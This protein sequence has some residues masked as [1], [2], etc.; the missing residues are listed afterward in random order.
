VNKNLKIKCIIFDITVLTGEEIDINDRKKKEIEDKYAKTPVASPSYDQTK[1]IK[2]VSTIQTKYM[3]KIRQR[4][5]D[6]SIVDA[7]SPLKDTDAKLLNIAK[8]IPMPNENKNPS[9]WLLQ[10][11]MGD[12]LDNCAFRS[13][14]IAV[15]GK[16]TSD[17]NII[18]QLAGQIP[19]MNFYKIHNHK[20][21]KE[22]VIDKFRT[23]EKQMDILPKEYLLFTSDEEIIEA[24]KERGYFTCRYRP[25]NGLYGRNSTDFVATNA[26]QCQDAIEELNGIAFNTSAY[27]SRAMN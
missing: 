5:G 19:N 18:D 3:N 6:K 20:D 15:I 21:D 22:R 26:I 11:G 1:E 16:N 10:T 27:N 17:P 12:L 8:A 24:G 7:T 2:N 4:I 23:M 25:Q 9:R 13:V 14:N